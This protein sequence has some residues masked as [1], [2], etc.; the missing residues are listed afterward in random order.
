MA[1]SVDFA[2]NAFNRKPFVKLGFRTV[3]GSVFGVG[4]KECVEQQ[5]KTVGFYVL[6]EKAVLIVN[7]GYAQLDICAVADN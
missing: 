3:K 2:L 1:F 7:A 5:L 6:A 4:V